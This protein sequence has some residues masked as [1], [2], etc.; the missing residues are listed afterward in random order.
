MAKGQ[1]RVPKERRTQGRQGQAETA[2]AYK[3][4]QIQGSAG[5]SPYS[6]RPARSPER[7]YFFCCG[8]VPAVRGV[9]AAF[10]ISRQVSNST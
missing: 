7:F 8:G 10:A 1:M 5:G 6:S 4:S 2:S 9:L 3:L